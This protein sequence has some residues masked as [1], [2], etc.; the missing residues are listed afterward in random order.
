GRR[1][2]F[3]LEVSRALGGGV[4]AVMIQCVS[5]MSHG[6]TL[7]FL[8]GKEFPYDGQPEISLFSGFII[9]PVKVWGGIVEGL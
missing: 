3:H 1:L 6:W 4:A 7:S 9:Y 5:R 8:P 2:Q